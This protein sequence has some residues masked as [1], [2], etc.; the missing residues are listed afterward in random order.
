L[1]YSLFFH[2]Q[3]VPGRQSHYTNEKK[4]KEL[5]EKYHDNSTALQVFEECIKE[6]K[7]YVKYSDY[8]GYEF[9]V[10]QKK[11][12]ITSKY[13]FIPGQKL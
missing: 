12:Q 1:T 4:I 11:E 2:S 6:I 7:M 8:F 13:R 10:M 9:F 5:Q 3:I